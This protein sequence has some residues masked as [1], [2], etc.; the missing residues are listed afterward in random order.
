MAP[1]IPPEPLSQTDWQQTPPVVQAHLLTLHQRLAQ[2]QQ[3]IE[4]LQQRSQRTSKTSDKPPSSDSPFHR[5]TDPTD[6][7]TGKRGARKGH[8]G[9]GPKLLRPTERRAIYPEPC[10]CGQGVSDHVAPYH[11][12]QVTELPPV[13]MAVTHWVFTRVG[14]RAAASCSEPASPRRSKA[15]MARA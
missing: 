10:P 7:P 2:L 14:V 8:P 12:H 13:E 1:S 6:K 4:Q 15:A 11:T 3:Q 5:P 9:S